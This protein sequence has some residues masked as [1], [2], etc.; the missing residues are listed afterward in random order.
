V[1]PGQ[2]LRAR[3]GYLAGTDAERAADVNAM[4]ADPEVDGIIA[5]RGGYGCARILPL[6]DYQT[7]AQ[8]PKILVGYSD[9]TALLLAIYQRTGL[10]TFHGPVANGGFNT[11]TASCFQQVLMAGE[12]VVMQNPVHKG[13]G[14][15]QVT[16]RI[17]TI[18]PGKASGVLAGGN[19]TVLCSIIGSGYLPDWAGKILFIEDI[20]EEV[21]KIDRMLT[22]LKLAGVLAGLRAIVVGKFTGSSPAQSYG[23]LTLEEVLI[24]HLQPLGIPVFAGA[25]IGHLPAKFTVPIGLEAEVDATLG[26][27]AL[28]GPAVR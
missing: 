19:L 16:D 4:F 10:V 2:F 11:F 5:M 17:R 26:T 24:D 28:R 6:L 9:V 14:L 22:Q 1:R 23:S 20:N 12:A 3:R 27:I 13:D 8:N 18:V 25:M 7:I 21:Y 15:V